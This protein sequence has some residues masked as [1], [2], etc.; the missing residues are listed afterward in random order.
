MQ[1]N[2][3]LDVDNAKAL[4]LA[5]IDA[6][7]YWQQEAAL[8]VHRL[9]LSLDERQRARAIKGLNRMAARL[10]EVGFV[11]QAD[12]LAREP[13]ELSRAFETYMASLGS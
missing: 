7:Q 8:E 6:D 1:G 4:L 13:D 11:L 2:G 12:A 10:R 9:G 3:V 5:E